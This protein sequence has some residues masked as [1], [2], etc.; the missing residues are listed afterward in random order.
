MLLLSAG[1]Q[2][3]SVVPLVLMYI[4]D[5]VFPIVCSFCWQLEAGRAK[6]IQSTFRTLC[7]LL[8]PPLLFTLRSLPRG[9]RDQGIVLA[10]PD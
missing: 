5:S 4:C 2:S 9:T 6:Q 8:C 10:S 1:T 7:R 3:V